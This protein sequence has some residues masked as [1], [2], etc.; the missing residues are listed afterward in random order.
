MVEKASENKEYD[1]QREEREEAREI[2]SKEARK[3][4]RKEL[5]LLQVG[6]LVDNPPY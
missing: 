3:E 4:G 2:G 6:T 1:T 5:H